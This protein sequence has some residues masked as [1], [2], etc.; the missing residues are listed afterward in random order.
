MVKKQ[1]LYR[2]FIYIFIVLG[3]GIP[4]HQVKRI[5]PVIDASCIPW[6]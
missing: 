4:P 5:Q 6:L 1:I 3:R 2:A